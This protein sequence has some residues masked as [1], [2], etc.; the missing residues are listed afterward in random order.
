MGAGGTLGAKAQFSTLG[1]IQKMCK[2]QCPG[3]GWGQGGMDKQVRKSENLPEKM[4][5]LRLQLL[6]NN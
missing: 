3:K 4:R 5:N 2:W 6:S 1:I